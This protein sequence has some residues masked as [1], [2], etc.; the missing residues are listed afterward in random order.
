M[1]G[2][3][4]RQGGIVHEEMLR[5]IL[6]DN[7]GDLEVISING[8]VRRILDARDRIALRL[9]TGRGYSNTPSLLL[10]TTEQERISVQA[11]LQALDLLVGALV[12]DLQEN[13][14]GPREI[15]V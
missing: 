8:T 15:M 2:G 12:G 7:S 13:T 1:S 4:P 9:A 6:G 14:E 11:L 3:V 10:C 5:Q